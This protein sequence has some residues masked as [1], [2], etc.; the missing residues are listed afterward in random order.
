M[1]KLLIIEDSIIMQKVIQHIAADELDCDIAIAD[2]FAQTKQLI[3]ENDYYLALAD[4]NL[5]D[6]TQGEVVDLLLSANITTIVLTAT[7]DNQH[8]QMMLQRG[9]LDYIFKENK[10]SYF[11]A[12]KLANQILN[13]QKI[14][15]L[16][17]NAD[18]EMR[19]RCQYL[20]EKMRFQVLA[21]NSGKQALARFEEHPDIGLLITGQNLAELD[22]IELIR[23]IRQQHSRDNFPI[24]GLSC[25]ADPNLSARFIKYG[26]N[27]F[28]IAPFVQEEFQWRI[29]KT[30]EQ[31]KL[32]Q[33]ITLSANRDFLTKLF[34]RRYF[35]NT[36]EDLLKL[37]I[38][39]NTSLSVVL[40]DIDFFKSVND[41][42]GHDSGDAVLIQVSSLLSEVLSEFTIA[43]YGGEEFIAV[44]DKLSK[45][46]SMERLEALRERVAK[47]TF[48]IPDGEICV[49]ISLGIAPL[50][51]PVNGS[52][53]QTQTDNHYDTLEGAIAKAD[54]A[55]Y[56]AKQ[57]G[58]NQVIYY[59]PQS[60]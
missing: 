1:S 37:A 24:I 44:L 30:I 39:N 22:G 27:D 56:Q 33:R 55:L 48:T 17:A 32:I 41:T 19:E 16:L 52:T 40:I 35:F 34:N 59:T 47:H 8:R 13:N 45:A 14:T 2:S 21:V 10:E 12:V 3:E 53:K 5:P 36:S 31:I 28:L 11:H 60:N 54:S 51:T 43:R 20:L 25:A 46:D 50:D 18:D 57:Q 4:L 49:T 9:V 58:R 6:A 29:L 7:L 26:A 42:Y 38:T 15:V 23:T